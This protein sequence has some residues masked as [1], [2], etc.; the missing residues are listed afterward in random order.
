MRK[1]FFIFCLMASAAGAQIVTDK[2]IS[3]EKLSRNQ[4]EITSDV[5]TH[6]RSNKI[7]IL[8][9]PIGGKSLEK[10]QAKAYKRALS[11]CKC[12]GIISPQY[13]ERK[14]I[15]PL[16]LVNLVHRS[17]R[18]KGKGYRLKVG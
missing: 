3:F 12:D 9:I 15:L 14:V 16:L 10:R 8:F 11:E 4:Y 7:W 1:L 18:V 13:S 6:S 2:N 5:V 17:T